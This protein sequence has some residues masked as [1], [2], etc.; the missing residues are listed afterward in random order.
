MT[1]IVFRSQITRS[2]KA[3]NEAKMKKNA[4]RKSV[5][6]LRLCLNSLCVC[7]CVAAGVALVSLHEQR[8]KERKNEEREK[9]ADETEESVSCKTVAWLLQ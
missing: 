6:I 7:A 9:S 2:P 8:K 3:T 4:K 1:A 5:G